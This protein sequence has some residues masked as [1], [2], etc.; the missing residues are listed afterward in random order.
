MCIVQLFLFLD[1]NHLSMEKRTQS[2]AHIRKH[3]TIA[4]KRLQPKHEQNHAHMKVHHHMHTVTYLAYFGYLSLHRCL[5]DFVAVLHVF[6]FL[7]S[8]ACISRFCW[9]TSIIAVKGE[10]CVTASLQNASSLRKFLRLGR[11]YKSDVFSLRTLLP[12]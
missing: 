7:C 12:W 9:C 6:V 1:S 11:L 2:C 10:D 5:V 8:R 4:K 3:T